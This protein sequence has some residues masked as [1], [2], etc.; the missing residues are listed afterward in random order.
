MERRIVGELQVRASGVGGMIE[1]I[2]VADMKETHGRI[3]LVAQQWIDD[4]W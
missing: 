4:G 1:R 3:T 2:L